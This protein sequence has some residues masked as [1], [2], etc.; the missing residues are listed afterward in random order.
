MWPVV[1]GVNAVAARSVDCG[2]PADSLYRMFSAG[3]GTDWTSTV[4]LVTSILAVA[5]YL[6]TVRRGNVSADLDTMRTLN[7]ALNVRVEA[8]EEH[9]ITLESRNRGLE[10]RVS[11]L[12]EHVTRCELENQRLQR[13]LARLGA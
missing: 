12:E 3:T 10:G 9:S 5:G 6:T 11:E 13:K 4:A 7:A 1:V 2:N 8:V